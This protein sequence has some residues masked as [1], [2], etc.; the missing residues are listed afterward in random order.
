MG[1]TPLESSSSKDILEAV[2]E[3]C[4]YEVNENPAMS[5]NVSV[6][7]DLLLGVGLA[8][9]CNTTYFI[10]DEFIFFNLLPKLEKCLDEFLGM[11]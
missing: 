7:V 11:K 4:R 10:I 5:F 8:C 3:R 6:C 1:N 9:G 2:I